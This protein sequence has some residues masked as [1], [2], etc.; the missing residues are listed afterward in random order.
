M[1]RI[2]RE[3]VKK[4]FSQFRPHQM[5]VP[6][7]WSYGLLMDLL[8]SFESALHRALHVSACASTLNLTQCQLKAHLF[9]NNHHLSVSLA[10]FH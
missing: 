7:I 4:D 6:S 3:R 10:G 1:K 9:H 8:E 5:L 2:K